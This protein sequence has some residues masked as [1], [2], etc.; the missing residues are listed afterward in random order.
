M[1]KWLRGIGGL[2]SQQLKKLALSSQIFIF[3]FAIENIITQIIQGSLQDKFLTDALPFLIIP[4]IFQ[5]FK[6]K[7]VF[8]IIFILLS[9]AMMITGTLGNFSGIVFLI[10][11]IYLFKNIKYEIIALSI[12]TLAISTN[13]YIHDLLPSQLFIMLRVYVFTYLIY[14]FTIRMDQKKLDNPVLHIPNPYLMPHERQLIEYL[15]EGKTRQEIYDIMNRSK[16]AINR[17]QNSIAGKFNAKTFEEALLKAG[18]SVK[19]NAISN[20]ADE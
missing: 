4:L 6:S 1:W 15:F 9:Y 16:S 7:K 13:A 11:S 8:S 19:I 14:F 5:F 18:K 2:H 3:S 17:Y 20:D 12:A 10:F